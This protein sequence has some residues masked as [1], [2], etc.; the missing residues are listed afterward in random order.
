VFSPDPFV[1]LSHYLCGSAMFS[2]SSLIKIF[3]KSKGTGKLVHQN[4]LKKQKQAQL[5]NKKTLK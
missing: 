1:Q 5:V 2:N 4:T 3:L